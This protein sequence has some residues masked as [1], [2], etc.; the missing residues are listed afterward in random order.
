MKMLIFY[1]RLNIKGNILPYIA[2]IVAILRNMEVPPLK[3]ALKHFTFNFC[4]ITKIT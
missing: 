3:M 4:K 1:T 2:H